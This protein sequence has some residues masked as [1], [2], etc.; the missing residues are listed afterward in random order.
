MRSLYRKTIP[1]M[2]N[3]LLS[4][5]IQTAD[6]R[7]TAERKRILALRYADKQERIEMKH[8]IDI[9]NDR[10][11]DNKPTYPN[12]DARK[13]E[14]I[15]RLSRD[16]SFQGVYEKELEL[17]HDI[18]DNDY[19]VEVTRAECERLVFTLNSLIKEAQ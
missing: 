14:L 9:F 18:L 11:S 8:K 17:Q 13:S 7:R 12:E 19:D 3:E 5:R 15:L 10:D 4:L 1:S 16:V 6:K 2:V